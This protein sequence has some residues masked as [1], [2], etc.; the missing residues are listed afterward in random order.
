MRGALVVALL[1]FLGSA[2]AAAGGLR[3]CTTDWPPF[4]VSASGAVGGVHAEVT[5]EAFRRLGHAVEIESVA[6]ERCWAELPKGTYQAVF[7]ASYRDE[8]AAVGLY[9]SV[10]LQSLSYVAVVRRGEGADWD[11]TD[12]ARLPLPLAAPRG[13]S[14]VED[15]RRRGMAVDDGAMK[16]AQ[17]VEKLLAG[18]IGTAVIEK[19]VAAVLIRDMGVGDRIEILDR[20]VG[21]PKDYFLVLGRKVGGTEA[22]AR[23]LARRLDAVLADIA[24]EGMAE[25]LLADQG[26]GGGR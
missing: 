24:R 8:R 15:L 10:P 19:S 7:S 5:R 13:Y 12:P 18:R 22:A 3:V 1:G 17:N 14:I 4:T 9:P 6:W 20:P 25:R 26:L 21:P 11:G 2:P 16:D 23:A